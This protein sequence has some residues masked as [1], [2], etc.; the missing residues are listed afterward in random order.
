MM[1]TKAV[2]WTQGTAWP[3][4]R[5][6]WL[7]IAGAIT[8]VVI[9]IRWGWRLAALLGVGG[10]TGGA[11]SALGDNQRRR[12]AEGQQLDARRQDLEGRA[13]ETGQM[14][15]AYYKNKGGPKS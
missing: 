11:A 2:K 5:G 10:T 6:H 4:I 1:W 7:W 12:E 13:K 3:W 8:L 15:D 14:I 9:G